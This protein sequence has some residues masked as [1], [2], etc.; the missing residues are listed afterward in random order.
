MGDLK[1][2]YVAWPNDKAKKILTLGSWNTY[3]PLWLKTKKSAKFWS[4]FVFTNSVPG[5]R[6]T[7]HFPPASLSHIYSNFKSSPPLT[8]VGPG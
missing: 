7:S 6:R 4:I 3:Q 1:A 5:V 2:L 8:G